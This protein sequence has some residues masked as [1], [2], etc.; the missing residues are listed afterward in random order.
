MLTAY[1]LMPVAPVRGRSEEE[2]VLAESAKFE[3]EQ[4]TK[5]TD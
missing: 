5:S 4:L 2:I 3:A 1:G